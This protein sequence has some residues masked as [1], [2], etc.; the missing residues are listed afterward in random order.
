MLIIQRRDQPRGHD[1]FRTLTIICTRLVAQLTKDHIPYSVQAFKR[2]NQK[3]VAFLFPL[4]YFLSV[5]FSC[6]QVQ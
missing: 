1:R 4:S 2:L 3:D 6:F 5:S